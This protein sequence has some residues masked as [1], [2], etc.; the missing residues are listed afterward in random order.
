MDEDGYPEKTELEYIKNFKCDKNNVFTLLDF[1]HDI[2]WCPEWG[3][4]EGKRVDDFFTTDMLNH[5]KKRKYKTLQLSTGGWS[6]NEDIIRALMDNK[7]FFLFYWV[8]STRGGHY[9][10]EFPEVK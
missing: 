9:C 2:W 10:F 6:G 4:V 1:V 7:Y 8:S 5:R 3:F